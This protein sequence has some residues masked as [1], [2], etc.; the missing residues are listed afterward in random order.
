MQQKKIRKK[1]KHQE[2]ETFK[3]VGA[4][5]IFNTASKGRRE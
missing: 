1:K 5:A 3:K 2:K 4:V